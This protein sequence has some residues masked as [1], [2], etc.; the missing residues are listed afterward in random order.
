MGFEDAPQGNEPRPERPKKLYHASLNRELSELHPRAESIRD[1]YEGPQVFATPDMALATI[2]LVPSHIPTK[3]GTHNGVPYIVIQE[4]PQAFNRRD[5]GGA[6]YELPP[7]GFGCE[8]DV[9]LG[10]GEWT[11]PATVKPIGKI[12]IPSA[13]D[14]MLEAGVQVYFADADTMALIDS[15]EDYGLARLRTMRSVNQRR[16]INVVEFP[17]GEES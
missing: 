11:C 16:G 12:E 3:S 5:K 7:D 6:I 15:D 13:L 4:D 1:S 14:A 17:E 8:P 2:F 9:G 10:E